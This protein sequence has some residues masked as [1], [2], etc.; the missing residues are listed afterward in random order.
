M[1]T[2]L[3]PLYLNCCLCSS[4]S[5]DWWV[6]CRGLCISIWS[7]L[8][9]IHF[10]SLGKSY[11]PGESI[12]L[13]KLSW[14]CTWWRHDWQEHT[15]R[16]TDLLWV[17]GRNPSD[18]W[19]VINNFHVVFVLMYYQAFWTNTLTL[20]WRYYDKKRLL[21]SCISSRQLIFFQ[22]QSSNA[23]SKLICIMPWK[24]TAT[25]HCFHR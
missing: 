14:C 19:T 15:F 16:I 3:K 5:H 17:C 20:V 7:L 13:L 22:Y 11:R 18:P 24:W 9:H 10:I 25:C 8:T 23:Y 12:K 21:F 6:C 4:C 2:L 1:Y